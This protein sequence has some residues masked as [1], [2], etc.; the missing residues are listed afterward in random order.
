MKFVRLLGAVLALAA[1]AATSAQAD[2]VSLEIAYLPFVGFSQLF[3]IDRE[4][5]ARQAGI[6]LKLTRFASGPAIVQALASGKFDAA[7]VGIGPVMVARAGGVDLK[8]VAANGQELVPLVGR[9]ALAEL[10]AQG[11]TPADSFAAYHAAAGRPAKIATLPKGSVPD[12]VLH[13]Y[14]KAQ[15]VAPSDVDILGVGEDQVQQLMLSKAV[16]AAV[17]PEP[18]PTVVLSRDSSARILA[19]GHEVMPGQPSG[20]LAVRQ[21]AIEGKR[22]AIQALVTLHKRATELMLDDP[23]R[24]LPY[25][26]AFIGQGLVDDDTLLR[27]LLASNRGAVR[28]PASIIGATMQLQQ[29]QVESGAQSRLVPTDELFD[30]SF[31]KAP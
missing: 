6:E 21:S 17:V 16:D 10:F 5:W 26:S 3:I 13:I 22:A 15:N 9:G 8:I 19:S 1:L 20:V 2:P 31:A 28:D 18:I 29:A 7:Y 23:K 14:L 11:K 27:A 30:L 24:V 4:G 25:V 12:T